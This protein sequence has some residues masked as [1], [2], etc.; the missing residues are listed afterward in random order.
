MTSMR[1]PQCGHEQASAV[2]CEQ[3]GIVFSK[4]KPH[5]I[6]AHDLPA[7]L[8][9]PL[10]TVLGNANVLRLNENPR[11]ALSMLTGWEISREFDIVDSVGRQR[12]SA[13]E[14]GQDPR[15]SR[16]NTYLRLAVDPVRGVRVSD[17]GAGD[18]AAP[19]VLLD[20]LRD[21]DRRRPRRAARIGEETVLTDSQTV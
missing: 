6:A 10:E 20:L 11:G 18:D 5:E 16:K 15:R 19:A 13:A 14:Q 2:E 3:C 7:G 4:W 21:D 12:G 9:S 17:S 8:P 1:C